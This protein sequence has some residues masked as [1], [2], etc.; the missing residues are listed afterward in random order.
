MATIQVADKPTLDAVKVLL[1][2]SGGV[3]GY[4]NV[5]SG[6]ISK[7]GIAVT[8]TGMITLIKALSYGWDSSI[9][10]DGVTL[11]KCPGPGNTIRDCVTFK[12]EKSFSIGNLTQD[13]DVYYYFILQLKN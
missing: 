8:G 3:S 7:S 4:P 1:E 12:F 13:Y 2:K 10:I 11:E 5:S 6:S 9:V